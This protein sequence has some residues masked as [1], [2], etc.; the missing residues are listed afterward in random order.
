MRLAVQVKTPAGAYARWAADEPDPRNVPDGLSFS[1]VMPGGCEHF[2]CTLERDP[3]R[4]YPDLEPLADIQVRSPG[5]TVAWQGRLEADPDTSG[6]QAQKQ[7]SASGYQ[8]HLMDQPAAMIYVDGVLSN[9]G[10]PP[11]AEQINLVQQSLQ[12]GSINTGWDGK[13]DL[14]NLV[15]E[16]DDTWAPTWHPT[17]E[18]WYDSVDAGPISAIYY[19]LNTHGLTAGSPKAN[20][21][22]RVAI[23]DDQGDATEQSSVELINVGPPS[24]TFK[25]TTAQRFGILRFHNTAASGGVSGGKYQAEWQVVV[26][27][28]HGLTTYG[29]PP[30]VLASDV[31]KHALS[32]WCPLISFTNT[33]IPDSSFVIPQLAFRDRTNAAEIIKQAASFE[34]LDWAIWPGPTAFAGPRDTLGRKWRALSGPAQ[35]QNAGNQ[36]ARLYNGVVVSYSSV[37]GQTLTVGPPGSGANVTDAS[38]LD[39]DPENPANQ[40]VD[41]SGN[42]VPKWAPLQ[43][44]GAT[45]SNGAIAAGAAFLQAQKDIDRSGSAVLTGYVQDEFGVWF[46]AW[47]PRAGDLI[48]FTDAHDTS[49]RRIVS[50]SYD[51]TTKASTLQLDQPPDTMTALFERLSVVLAAAGL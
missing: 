10:D 21:V 26:L 29:T 18:A 42:I 17:V 16:I 24:G 48:A 25:P 22:A 39:T 50:K 13:T 43:M 23:T 41:S 4:D 33:S 15:E 38:L 19:S 1:D 2:N 11:L 37:S 3:R 9:W 40:V 46:P 27:G 6:S 31:I 32:T 49:Y 14:P 30:G 47:A 45:T 7:P 51:D 8:S 28:N 36:A 35:L 5:G 44:Q 20:W 34:I 12:Q